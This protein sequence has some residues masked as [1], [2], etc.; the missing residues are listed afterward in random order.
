MVVIGDM[1]AIVG[2]G[3]SV[4]DEDFGRNGEEVCNNNGRWLVQFSS[5]HNF[6]VS[7]TWF[8]HK[9]IHKD[10]HLGI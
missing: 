9:R 10:V 3:T 4:W 7:N 5:E 6:R 1:N 8:P 2:C